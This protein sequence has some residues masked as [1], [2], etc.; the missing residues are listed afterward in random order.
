MLAMPRNQWWPRAACVLAT[1]VLLV[2]I[3]R[4]IEINSILASISRTNPIWVL[5]GAAFYGFAILCCGFRWHL[6]LK[7]TNRSLHPSASCRLVYIGHF[8]VTALCGA[9]GGDFAKSAVYAR[10]YR[11]GLPEVVAAA[12]LDRTMGFG[13]TVALG[14]IVLTC[15]VLTGSFARLGSLDIPKPGVW[16]LVSAVAI[17]LVV[18]GVIFWHPKGESSIAR[19]IRAFRTGSARMVVT[20][21]FIIPGVLLSLLAQASWSGTFALNLRAVASVPVPWTEVLWVFAAITVV[22]G[23]SF[24]FGGAGVREIAALTLLAPYGVPAG[25]CVAAAMLTFLVRVVWAGAGALMLWREEGWQPKSALRAAPRTISVV[26]PT[27]NEAQALSETI[28]RAQSLLE[29]TEII[30]VDAGSSD[31]TAA[32]AARLG[33]RVIAGQGG[34]GAQ[35]RLGA[36]QASGDVI[37]LLHADT[38]LPPHAGRAALNCLRDTTVVAGGFWKRFRDGPL[39]LLGSRFRCGIRLL[40]GGRILGDQVL[41]IRREVL[42]AIG[43]VPD[44]PLMEEIE[45][46]RRLRRAG[47]LA[48]ADAVVTTS[49]RRFRE[50]GVIRAYLR[51]WRVATLYRLG[52]SPGRLAH[53]YERGVARTNSES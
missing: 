38:W 41:F 20:P 44:Q 25:D 40:L 32:I 27:L 39:L 26:I 49:A 24:T 34:R 8:F 36:Q 53:L 5:A 51:M 30:V 4:R 48:L 13:G 7:L 21:H 33:C 23:L 1:A 16:A 45:L 46:C 12:P 10:W 47:R 29:V 52:V 2:V 14:A 15:A 31:G 22:T 6:S 17:T 3:F 11:F 50:L 35:M 42:K 43:G 18:V 9:A 28:R 37:M 19:T